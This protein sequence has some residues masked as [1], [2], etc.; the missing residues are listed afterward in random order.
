MKAALFLA[1]I[2]AY[3]GSGVTAQIDGT[4]YGWLFNGGPDAESCWVQFNDGYVDSFTLRAGQ[5]SKSYWLE[6]MYTW[7]CY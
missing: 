7:G 2:L 5:R 4:G 1:L 3:G 6:D